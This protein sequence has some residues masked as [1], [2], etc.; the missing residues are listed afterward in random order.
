MSEKFETATLGAG[1]FWC[2]EAVFSVING[3]MKVE[4]GYS[5]AGRVRGMGEDRRDHLIPFIG[6]PLFLVICSYDGCIR[7]Y[8][9]GA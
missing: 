8:A 9:L 2:I 7:I 5:G 4:S 6:L 3:V 1:C